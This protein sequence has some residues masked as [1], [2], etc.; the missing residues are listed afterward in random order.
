MI[1]L[2]DLAKYGLDHLL[3]KNDGLLGLPAWTAQKKPVP[4]LR[5]ALISNPDIHTLGKGTLTFTVDLYRPIS[6]D[7]KTRILSCPLAR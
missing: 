6:K 3:S 4:V 1:K 7:Q 5:V 2:V